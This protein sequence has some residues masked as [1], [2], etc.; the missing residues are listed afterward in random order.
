MVAMKDYSFS[1]KFIEVIRSI[2][3][4]EMDKRH[5]VRIATV[6]SY[7]R[8]AMTCFVQFV[9]APDT[10]VKVAMNAVQPKAVGQRVR[11]ELMDGDW[12]LTHVLSSG[13]YYST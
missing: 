5:K 7:D 3:R 6:V 10:P 13:A 2:V 4:A 11:V 8:T 12:L 9:E 1:V